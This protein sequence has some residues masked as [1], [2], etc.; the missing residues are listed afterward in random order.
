MD[1]LPS[2]ALQLAGEVEPVPFMEGGSAI[3]TFPDPVQP[4][5]SDTVTE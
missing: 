4:R 3:V 2:E 5:L 1:I